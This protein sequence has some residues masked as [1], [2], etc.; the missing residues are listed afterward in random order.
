MCNCKPCFQELG[1]EIHNIP[2]GRAR[3]PFHHEAVDVL[4]ALRPAVVSFHFG[5][6]AGGHRGMFLSQD[7]LSQ[8]ETSKLSTDIVWA[9]RLPVIAEGGIASTTSLQR[10]KG[11]GAATSHLCGPARAVT[12]SPVVPH[13]KSP[14]TFSM[15]GTIDQAH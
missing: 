1:L 15:P 5:L 4:Q 12:T 9:L 8:V 10:A 3:M 11:A 2:S 13:R 14:A 7:L 6:E